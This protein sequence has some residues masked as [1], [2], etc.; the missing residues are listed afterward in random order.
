MLRPILVVVVAWC[1]CGLVVHAD[2]I[3]YDKAETLVDEYNDLPARFGPQFPL[4]GESRLF[5]HCYYYFAHPPLVAH[6]T[7][8]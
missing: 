5:L 6:L 7:A 2:V 1:L 4:D 8:Y 3:V